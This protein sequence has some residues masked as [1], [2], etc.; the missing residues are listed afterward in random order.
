MSTLPLRGIV[1][2]AF[3]HGRHELVLEQLRRGVADP[4]E[5]FSGPRRTKPVLAWLMR[6]TPRGHVC[7][8]YGRVI[9]FESKAHSR[10]CN[11]FRNA[12]IG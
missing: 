12:A 9:L 1:G 3:G 2:I 6:Y 4:Q 5:P 10:L 7:G 11:C 8:I